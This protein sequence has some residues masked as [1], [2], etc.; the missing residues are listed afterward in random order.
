MT[1]VL[2]GSCCGIEVVDV[3]RGFSAAR[4]G[5]GKVDGGVKRG[6]ANIPWLGRAN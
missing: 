2:G 6:S 1:S 4:L 3:D 5:T